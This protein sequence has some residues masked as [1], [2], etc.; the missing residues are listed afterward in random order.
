[1][2]GPGEARVWRLLALVHA[3]E[4][5]AVGVADGEGRGGGATDVIAMR[6]AHFIPAGA[7]ERGREGG[8]L[9]SF[10]GAQIVEVAE[11]DVG[12]GVRRILPRADERRGRFIDDDAGQ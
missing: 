12:R 6:E 11:A 5:L 7:R 10:I 3:D 9:G 2:A 8:G 4:G 1:V